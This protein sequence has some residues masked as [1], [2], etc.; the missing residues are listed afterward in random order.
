[1]FSGRKDRLA[2]QEGAAPKDDAKRDKKPTKL[3][4][5]KPS[6]PRDAPSST[7]TSVSGLAPMGRP[8]PPAAEA[9]RVPAASHF[10]DDDEPYTTGSMTATGGG[11]GEG[12]GVEQVGPCGG[13]E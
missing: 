13:E 6:S 3:V 7:N 10:A 1:M 2:K 5:R 9:A 4:G 11:A 12:G 8:A